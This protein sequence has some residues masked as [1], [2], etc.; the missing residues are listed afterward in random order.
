MYKPKIIRGVPLDEQFDSWKNDPEILQQEVDEGQW[1]S[2]LAQRVRSLVGQ[3]LKDGV[4]VSPGF[5]IQ[6]LDGEPFLYDDVCYDDPDLSDTINK[7]S[8]VEVVQVFN[9]FAAM[10]EIVSD[11][12]DG[13]HSLS[14]QDKESLSPTSQLFKELRHVEDNMSRERI[15]Q[16]LNTG[17]MTRRWIV[18]VSRHCRTA[19]WIWFEDKQDWAFGGGNDTSPQNSPN[20]FV[21]TMQAVSMRVAK[22]SGCDPAGA[23]REVVNLWQVCTDQGHDAWLY[24]RRLTFRELNRFVY[25]LEHVAACIYASK[26]SDDAEVVEFGANLYME[27]RKDVMGGIAMLDNLLSEPSRLEQLL[28]NV[29]PEGCQRGFNSLRERTEWVRQRIREVDERH[30]G[31]NN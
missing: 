30:E 10:E 14:H 22:K 11:D 3:D 15:E 13:F 20:P 8:A 2:P 21:P 16:E 9:G 23:L 26:D 12:E 19:I 24:G 7:I 18:A 1:D 6:P 31:A 27:Y 5:L 17:W 25:A 4:E 28:E 29:S